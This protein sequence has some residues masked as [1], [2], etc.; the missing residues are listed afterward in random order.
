MPLDPQAT[1]LV[2]RLGRAGVVGP[3]QL[4]VA[5]ARH[6]GLKIGGTW[7]LDD[8]SLA[9]VAHLSRISLSNTSEVA[10]DIG[11]NEEA[12]EELLHSLCQSGY[13]RRRE[14]PEGEDR[15]V[16]LVSGHR[17]ARRDVTGVLAALITDGDPITLVDEEEELP[18]GTHRYP[19][20]DDVSLRVYR[21]GATGQ[22]KLPVVYFIHGG[23]YVT[24]SVDEYKEVCHSTAELSGCAVVGI[25]YRLAPEH[26][27]PAAFEDVVTGL[28]WLVERAESLGLDRHRMAVMGDSVGG[29]LSTSLSFLAQ[30]EGWARFLVQILLYPALDTSM[31]LPSYRLHADGPV[32]SS[33]DMAWYYSHY[34]A[35][36]GEATSSPLSRSDL[37][38]AAPALILTAEVD[39]V[40]D[41]G[42]DY[43]NRLR[44]AGNEVEHI[45]CEGVFHGF[46]RFSPTLD[47]ATRA[48]SHVAEVLNRRLNSGAA[49]DS[50]ALE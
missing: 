13:V 35:P 22:K 20:S 43:A 36:L 3:A 50:D 46:Y 45:E 2:A 16:C 41:D 31:S 28:R 48:R 27:F 14:D 1:E 10:H 37:S 25:D 44:Q 34:G 5:G 24:G 11:L 49:I 23:G 29:A 26:P 12:T 39:P 4:T 21:P 9:V 38:G 40:H 6:E 8:M 19:I 17:R 33:A 15:W 47:A 30:R 42:V 32:T 18:D 7:L